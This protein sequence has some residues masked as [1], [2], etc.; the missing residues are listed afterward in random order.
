MPESSL[1]PPVPAASEEC[2]LTRAA[3]SHSNMCMPSRAMEE[4]DSKSF[5]RSKTCSAAFRTMS[6]SRTV[7]MPEASDKVSLFQDSLSCDSAVSTT[8]RLSSK[9]MRSMLPVCSTCSVDCVR[10]NKAWSF[11]P[12]SSLCLMMASWSSHLK[13]S[14]TFAVCK[15]CTCCFFKVWRWGAECSS[16]CRTTSGSCLYTRRKSFAK[17]VTRASAFSTEERNSRISM[18]FPKSAASE[19]LRV[20]VCWW[21]WCIWSSSIE[22]MVCSSS[23]CWSIFSRKFSSKAASALRW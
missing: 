17:R 5:T 12:N 9:A 18:R 13:W 3:V 23:Q 7:K 16:F 15:S 22:R 10:S 14:V 4:T 8:S 11:E 1:L 2:D 19:A 20:M 21:S 6:R